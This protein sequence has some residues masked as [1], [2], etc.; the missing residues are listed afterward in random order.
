MLA[1]SIG[2]SDSRI[3]GNAW[4]S[5]AGGEQETYFL[6]IA[7]PCP[8][9][10]ATPFVEMTE[11]IKMRAAGKSAEN[12]S[13]WQIDRAL[14]GATNW[15]A[16]HDVLLFDRKTG[17]WCQIDHLVFSRL[18]HFVVLETKSAKEG[19]NLHEPSGGFS[20]L[21]NGR[22]LP[23]RS[24]IAQNYRHI[25]ILADYLN[26]CNVLPKRFGLLPIRPTFENWVLVQPGSPVPKKYDGAR[27]VQRD[28]FSKTF[29]AFLEDISVTRIF[30]LMLRSELGL[31]AEKL[32]EE[33]K[34]NRRIC[35]QYPTVAEPIESVE[36]PATEPRTVQAVVHFVG[37]R[38]TCASCKAVLTPKEY[39]FCKIHFS[40]L[41]KKFLCKKCQKSS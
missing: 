16:L 23:V 4:H 33:S 36:T 1:D 18:G 5:D 15:K 2:D 38:I 37:N 24:P 26:G 34:A 13:R 19:M 3:S 11:E 40:K 25:E 41:G 32:A 12:E 30:K 39:G 14:H 10:P 22:A 29:D 35:E 9:G 6:K 27:L 17:G 28:Q 20:V 31:V 8:S 7:F 21:F